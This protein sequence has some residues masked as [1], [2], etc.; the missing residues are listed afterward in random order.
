M[1]GEVRRYALSLLGEDTAPPSD[2]G[3]FGFRL[4]VGYVL[5][6]AELFIN[7]G[8]LPKPGGWDDQDEDW[9]DDLQTFLR[10]YNAV[11]H[12]VRESKKQ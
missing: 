9:K 5:T 7:K 11:A 3:D 6:T 4:P 8:I 10:V 2:P 12:E 1:Q